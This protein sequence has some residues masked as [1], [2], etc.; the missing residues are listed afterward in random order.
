MGVVAGSDSRQQLHFLLKIR[1][2]LKAFDWIQSKSQSKLKSRKE[3]LQIC[4]KGNPGNRV[5]FLHKN[6]EQI[7][8]LTLTP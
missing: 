8:D 4:Q 3:F 5:I 7:F 2:F 1:H 6:T